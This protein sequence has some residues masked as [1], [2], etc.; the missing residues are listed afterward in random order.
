M[1]K[2]DKINA[3]I[4]GVMSYHYVTFDISVLFRITKI[5]FIHNRPP[6]VNL[7]IMILY[8][9]RYRHHTSDR[10]KF[11]LICTH[12]LSQP[13]FQTL[14]SVTITMEDVITYATIFMAPLPA[15]VNVDM[16]WMKIRGHVQVSFNTKFTL[17]ATLYRF[18]CN[19]R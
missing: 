1:T 11:C 8:N 17:V 10:F 3:T 2:D 15:P 19:F 7:V 16:N 4:M 9:T 12:L 18:P 5:S 6:L 13:L 14:M